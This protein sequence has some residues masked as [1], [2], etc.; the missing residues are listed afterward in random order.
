[1]TEATSTTL[2]KK[3]DT[4]PADFRFILFERVRPEQNES[5][6]Y[7]LAYLPT[8]L[9]DGAVIRLFGRKGSTQRAVTPQPFESLEEAWPLLRQIIRTR[10]NHGYRIVQPENLHPIN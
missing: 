2:K 1:M 3:W 4:P 7:Y 10:L 9:D 6:F 8:L 5:R